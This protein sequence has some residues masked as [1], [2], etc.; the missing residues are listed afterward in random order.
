MRYFACGLLLLIS[1]PAHAFL[2]RPAVFAALGAVAKAPNG[3]QQFC[4]ENPG[5]CRS[6]GAPPRDVTL[7]P[8]LL[9]QLY[10]INGLVNIRVK[11]TSDEEL[12]GKPERWTYPLDRGD[13]EDIVLLKRRMLAEA[14]WPLSALLV[15]TV[16]EKTAAKGHH[17]V[18]TVRTDHGEFILDNQTP[19]ILFADETNYHYLIRQSTYDPNV[20]VTFSPNRPITVR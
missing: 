3:W 17:A 11:W 5:E 15:T 7:T 9:Q 10:A 13:C 16:E 1:W 12:Y 8:E 19:E 14:G 18:L 4:T 20:W 2:A 6:D